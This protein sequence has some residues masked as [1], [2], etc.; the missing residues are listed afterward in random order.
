MSNTAGIVRDAQGRA[1]TIPG[2]PTSGRYAVDPT[3]HRDGG[4]LIA[5]SSDRWPAQPD[6]DQMERAGAEARRRSAVNPEAGHDVGALQK[7]LSYA[8]AEQESCYRAFT[9]GQSHP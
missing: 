5:P 3:R 7:R 9:S 6:A 1:R 8:I 2:Q 4:S